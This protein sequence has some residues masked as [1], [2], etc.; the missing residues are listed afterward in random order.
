MFIK[1]DALRVISGEEVMTGY[2]AKP[3][4][5]ASHTFCKFCGMRTFERGH[6][7]QLGGDYVAI[8]VSSLDD[9]SID[10]IMSGSVRFSDGRNNNW[11]NPP[12]DVRNL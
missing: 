1:R 10:E 9:A 2:Q 6:L 12:A 3:E 4:T 5:P 11:M 7:E 8:H